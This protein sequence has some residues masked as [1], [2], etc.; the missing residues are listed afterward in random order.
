MLRG[1]PNLV[2]ACEGGALPCEGGA[3]PCPSPRQ[4][5][6]IWITVHQ[7]NVRCC[8]MR[9][10]WSVGWR[11]LALQ[12]LAAACVRAAGLGYLVVT[13]PCSVFDGPLSF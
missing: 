2:P 12:R 13:L 1:I 8:I 3:L 5:Q 11:T 10:P 9:L 6:S 4:I 7:C